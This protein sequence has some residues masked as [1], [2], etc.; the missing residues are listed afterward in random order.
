MLARQRRP[1]TCQA[2][3][4]QG[5]ALLVARLRLTP[6][7]AVPRAPPPGRL[8]AQRSTQ[9]SLCVQMKQYA[10]FAQLMSHLLIHKQVRW[11]PAIG[12]A[13]A[14]LPIQATVPPPPAP[15]PPLAARL[16][17]PLHLPLCLLR[18]LCLLCQL[19]PP[20][21]KPSSSPRRRRPETP[22]AAITHATAGG[23]H[24]RLTHASH[25]CCDTHAQQPWCVH[26]SATPHTLACLLMS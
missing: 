23:Q 3:S 6:H 7:I 5:R 15:P 19:G 11:S 24:R 9:K 17:R 4:Q 16:P 21:G 12:W 25:A 14:P 22:A 2:F 13:A 1:R 20:R 18:L 26:A 8:T 10:S